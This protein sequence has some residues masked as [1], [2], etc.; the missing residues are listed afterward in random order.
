MFSDDGSNWTGSAKDKNKTKVQMTYNSE[1]GL[2]IIK[3]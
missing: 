2:C 3:E 1:V